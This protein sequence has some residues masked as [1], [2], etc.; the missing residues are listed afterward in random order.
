MPTARRSPKTSADSGI[1]TRSWRRPVSAPERLYRWCRRNPKVAA[2]TAAVAVLLLAV[3][4][5]SSAFAATLKTKNTE[6]T[7]ARDD[8]KAKQLLA[9]ASERHVKEA[10]VTANE[11]NDVAVENVDQLIDL[12]ENRLRDEPKLRDVRQ[13]ILEKSVR[14]LEALA[15]VMNTF[16]NNAR[17]DGANE[18]KNLRKLARA[19][20]RLGETYL[21]LEDFGLALDHF[22]KANDMVEYLAADAS[23]NVGAKI[24]LARVQR[25]L[26]FLYM[27][28]LSDSAAAMPCLR[29]AVAID[30]ECLAT[31]PKSDGLKLELANSLGILAGAEMS[32]GHL[33][34]AQKYYREE[35][36]LRNGLAPKTAGSLIARRELSGLYEKLAEW[37]TKAGFL[38]KAKVCYDRCKKIRE[39]VWRDAPDSWPVNYDLARSYNNEAFL[40]YPQGNDP[41]KARALHAKALELIQRRADVDPGDSKVLRALS[42]TLYYEATCALKLGDSSGA[43]QGYK[44]CLEIRREAAEKSKDKAVQ[45]NYMVALGRCGDHALAARIADG[46]VAADPRNEHVFFHVACGYALASEAA[47]DAREE[48]R[49]VEYASKAIEALQRAK[50]LGWAEVDSLRTDPDLEPIR[51]NPAFVAFL[52]TFKPATATP[53]EKP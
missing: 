7:K 35:L 4:L 28:R 5:G 52:D 47:T 50:A 15:G 29:R 22:R 31:D 12:L 53:A 2:L 45:I 1:T 48:A 6:L 30:R 11:Q 17:W 23:S 39:E 46:L 34:D 13:S 26:G 32:L 27:D 40:L 51:K 41:E 8:A 37:N 3:S 21:S 9:E 18:E 42:E 33:G 49:A 10:I 20:Q 16:R 43:R 44:R 14:N 24:R 36:T 38:D 19:H 25:N